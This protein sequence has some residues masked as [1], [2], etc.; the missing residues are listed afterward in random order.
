MLVHAIRNETNFR[1]QSQQEISQAALA[2]LYDQTH[3]AVFGLLLCLLPERALAEEILLEVYEEIWHTAPT[4]PTLP[5]LLRLARQRA[6]DRLRRTPQQRPTPKKVKV[7]LDSAINENAETGN[8]DLA[9]Q[10]QQVRRALMRLTAEERRALELSYFGALTP[11]EIAAHLG[12]T[13]DEVKSLLGAGLRRLKAYLPLN[14]D[15]APIR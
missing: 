15:A 2:T 10:R 7:W 13:T 3:R 8:D 6:L 14:A 4:N 12:R 9:E 11:T 5:R 1:A